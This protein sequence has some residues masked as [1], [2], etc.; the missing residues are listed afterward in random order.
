[1][2]HDRMSIT[3]ALV[4]SALAVVVLLVAWRALRSNRRR[5]KLDEAEAIL[6]QRARAAEWSPNLEIDE[7]RHRLHAG[8]NLH[9]MDWPGS[10]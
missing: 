3:V 6:E 8:A 4:V 2:Y 9:H 1:M 5:S 10:T 7:V